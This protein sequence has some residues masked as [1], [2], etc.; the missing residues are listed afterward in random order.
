METILRKLPLEKMEAHINKDSA[1]LLPLIRKW[2]NEG[3]LCNKDPEVIASVIRTL[4]LL[5]LHKKEIGES[6][7]H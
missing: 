3:I 7:Y 5:P 6:V 2:Q 4:F 1:V